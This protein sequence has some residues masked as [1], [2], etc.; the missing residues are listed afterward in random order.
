VHLLLTFRK[1]TYVNCDSN[2]CDE[3]GMLDDGVG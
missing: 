2:R 1:D 3:F